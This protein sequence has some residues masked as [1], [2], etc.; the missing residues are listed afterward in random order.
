MV[1]REKKTMKIKHFAGYGSVNAKKIAL[2]KRNNTTTLIIDVSG[3]HE[4]GLRP[5][6]IEDSIKWIAARFYS[7][8]LNIP[9]YKIY[10]DYEYILRP[11]TPETI[12]YIFTIED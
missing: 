6:I 11:G 1:K 3:D 9:T 5:Y 12:E 10:I 7:Y 8:I 4:K 2:F